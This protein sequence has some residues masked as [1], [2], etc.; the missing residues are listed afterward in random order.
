M[1]N[2]ASIA[3]TAEALVIDTLTA[4]GLDLV[5]VEYVREGGA[6]F[7]RFYVDK[8]GGVSIDDCAE[9][10]RAIDPLLDAGLAISDSYYLEVSSPGLTRP[11]KKD[12]DF[13]RHLGEQ[14]E[15]S[16][17][18]ARDGVKR[19]EGELVSYGVDGTLLLRTAGGGEISFEKAETSR[20]KRVIQF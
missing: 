7:L 18:Q 3:Q 13:Q 6:R 10:S 17:Y 15:V 2:R 19:F 9:A 1:A 14:V 11:L 16:L 20:V 5:D 12:A 4:M 8:R